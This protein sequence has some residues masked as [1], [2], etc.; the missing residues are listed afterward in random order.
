M[1]TALRN[2][3]TSIISLPPNAPHF[4]PITLCSRDNYEPALHAP[5]DVPL[6]STCSHTHDRIFIR[7]AA[8]DF[9]CYSCFPSNNAPTVPHV[10]MGNIG[11]GGS[12]ESRDS[13]VRPAVPDL[14]IWRL[15]W[16]RLPV[17]LSIRPT[18]VPRH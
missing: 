1:R 7:S 15:R 16:L 12:P 2:I 4:V 14:E 17:S 6:L 9:P 11:V 10:I 18:P 3:R 5:N 8:Y 13:I